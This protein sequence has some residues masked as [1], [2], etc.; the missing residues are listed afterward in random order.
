MQFSIAVYALKMYKDVVNLNL[1]ARASFYTHLD[2]VIIVLFLTCIG[3]ETFTV[4]G[5]IAGLFQ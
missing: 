5:A 4:F 2:K 3:L 1:S